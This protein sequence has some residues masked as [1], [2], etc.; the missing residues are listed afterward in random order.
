MLTYGDGVTDLNLRDVLK[1]HENHGKIGTLTGVVP[2]SRYGEL[3]L[4]GDRVLSF[5]EKPRH[6][7]N[8]ING[9]Y[10]VFNKAIFDYLEENE[11]CILEREPLENLAADDNLRIFRHPGFWQCMDTP[12]DYHFLNDLCAHGKAPWEADL[13]PEDK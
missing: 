3:L 2:P 10:F 11:S 9:G 13:L 7:D 8:S 1:F 4:Q 5:S 12:R 6:E